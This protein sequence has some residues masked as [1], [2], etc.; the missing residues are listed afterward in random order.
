VSARDDIVELV[1]EH[2]YTLMAEMFER[3]VSVPLPHP[4]LRRTDD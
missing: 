3:P 4:A 2:I 1:G